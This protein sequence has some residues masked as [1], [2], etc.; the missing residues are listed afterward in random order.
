VEQQ[1]HK[2]RRAFPLAYMHV[3]VAG[4]RSCAQLGWMKAKPTRHMSPRE[5]WV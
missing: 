2:K 4:A 3:G 1:T 5:G